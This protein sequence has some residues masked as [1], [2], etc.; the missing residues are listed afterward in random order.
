MLNDDIA[1]VATDIRQHVGSGVANFVDQLFGHSGSKHH[2]TGSWWLAHYK[3][4]ILNAIDNG[5]AD[6]WP[7]RDVLPVGVKSSCGLATAL[8][9]V[10]CKATTS[11]PVVIHGA[12]A[13]LMYQRTQGGRT[14][15]AATRD[16]DIGSCVEG[17]RHG[18]CTEVS[19]GT[20]YILWQGIAREHVLAFE[21][22]QLRH[23]ARDVVT[24]DHRDPR[25][26][27]LALGQCT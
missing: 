7:V 11:Q 8:D 27:S 6:V 4:A 19:T 13:K 17:S 1:K 12:P 5:V 20:Q 9:D 18:Q 3:A 15:H 26:Q 25:L 22:P 21:A 10:A 14:V 23:Q 2:T 16:N 24:F